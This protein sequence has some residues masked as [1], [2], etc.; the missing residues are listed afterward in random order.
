MSSSS[1]AVSQH[2]GHDGDISNLAGVNRKYAFD[3]PAKSP[4]H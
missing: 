3:F 1:D 4:D 2:A